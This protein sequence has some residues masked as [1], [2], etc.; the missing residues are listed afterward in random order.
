M[1]HQAQGVIELIF[2][3]K[4][5]LRDAFPDNDIILCDGTCNCAFHQKCLDP[6]LATENI[7]P[8][9]QGW[10]CKFCECKMEILDAVNAHLGTQF[11]MNS[12]WQDVFKE[13]AELPDGGSASLNPEEEWPSDDSE[14]CDYDPE[15]NE[16][17]CSETSIEDNISDDASSFSS[18]SWSFGEE[19]SLQ[20]RRSGDEDEGSQGRNTMRGDDN[21]FV[22]SFI[23]DAS[24]NNIDRE[25]KSRCRQ[26]KDVDY[27]KLHDEMF[28]K[29]VAENEQVSEDEDWGPGRKTRREKESDAVDTLMTLCENENACSNV[30]PIETKE[31]KHSV[32]RDKKPLFRIPPSAV[33]KLRQ[34][35]AENE[36]PSRAV[37]EDLSNQL[38]LASEKVNKWFKNARYTA[39]RIRK[40]E[41]M[42]ELGSSISIPEDSSLE[43]GKYQ[44]AD[45]V[46]LKDNPSLVPSETGVRMPK[47]LRKVRA[48]KN[49]KSII[50]L[51]KKKKHK[52]ATN[53]LLTNKNEVRKGFN[54]LVNLKKQMSNLKRKAPSEKRVNLKS[55]RGSSNVDEM[56][57]KEKLYMAEMERLCHL[58]DRIEKL[59][60]VLLRIQNGKNLIRDKTHSCEQVVIYVP[61]AE[62]REK[63]CHV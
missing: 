48:R 2:C 30:V 28:G 31:K 44:T 42:K 37:K 53:A 59:K 26:R 61:V 33:E 22:D 46:A 18:L 4:C 40:A 57:K 6:P 13:A 1:G 55:K 41:S 51:L 63:Q 56:K 11:P 25:I 7:P 39:L 60:K 38:G 27:K 5:K 34:V 3:A 15:R 21:K 52:K 17:S 45:Q 23:G 49:P 43:I 35:F 8:G 19:A 16:K 24:Y 12:N 32:S 47:N 36:L 62:I 14:D 50:S 9:D 58:E 29:D 10:Y 54:S 20:S